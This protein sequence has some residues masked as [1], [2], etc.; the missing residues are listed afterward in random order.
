MT[1]SASSAGSC[2]ALVLDVSSV[3][4][5]QEDDCGADTQHRRGRADQLEA[6]VL[7]SCWFAGGG[8]DFRNVTKDTSLRE[9]R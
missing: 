1:C 3:N 2:Q 6:I 7:T 4:R 8:A 5:G 9:A